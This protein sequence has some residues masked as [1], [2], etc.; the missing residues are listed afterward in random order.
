MYEIYYETQ[1]L[2]M[3]RDAS[4]TGLGA[5]LLQTVSGTSC[6]RDKAP[7]ISILRLITFASKIQQH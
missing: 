7:D 4:G 2:Y 5:A 1:P 3:E 6:P